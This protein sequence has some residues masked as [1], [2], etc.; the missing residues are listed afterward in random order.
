MDFMFLFRG[1]RQAPED[2]MEA[3]M[4]KWGTWMDDLGD[5]F[6]GGGPLDEDGRIL[7]SKHGEPEKGILAN[8]DAEVGGYI[9]IKA[10]SID[11][12]VDL[13]RGCPIYEV[14]GIVEVREIVR[15]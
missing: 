14:D 12:A 9:V 5:H 6:V 11:D 13:A 2:E 15:M 3:R 10:D 7:D 4:A 1:G 8:G